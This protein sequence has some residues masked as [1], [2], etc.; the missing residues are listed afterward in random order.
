MTLRGEE[1]ADTL[2]FRCDTADDY[3]ELRPGSLDLASRDYEAHAE[4]VEAI[5]AILELPDKVRTVLAQDNRIQA[6]AEKLA[7]RIR[8]GVFEGL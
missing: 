2:V 8:R 3:A 4:G 5:R 7:G 6:I 1:G